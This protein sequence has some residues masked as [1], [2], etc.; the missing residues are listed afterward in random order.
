[1]ALLTARVEAW[2]REDPA[3]WFWM[4]RRWKDLERDEAAAAA[5]PA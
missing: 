4:H 2:I 1:M 5:K 3:Q